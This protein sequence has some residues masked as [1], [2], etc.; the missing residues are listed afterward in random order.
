RQAYF[1]WEHHVS[2]ELNYYLPMPNN[3]QTKA[4]LPFLK[5][6]YESFI[7]AVEQW[8]GKKI[9]DED[10]DR[11]IEIMNRNRQLMRRVYETRKAEMP[12]IS[13]LEAMYMVVSSQLTHKE[14]HSDVLDELLK[15]ELPGRTVGGEDDIRL[16]SVGSE[17]DDIEFT[18][19]VESVG[20][21]IVI[22]DHCTGTRYFWS[23]VVP[24]EDRLAAIAERYIQRTACPTKDWPVRSRFEQIK[25]F[26]RDFDV[27]GVILVQQ[28][29]CDPH[30]IDFAALQDMLEEI[31]I[32]TLALEFDV[33]VPLGPFRIRVEAFLET[34]GGEELF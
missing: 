32:K 28:K 3:V 31:G 17:N 20:G 11:G 23:E 13:G 10:L 12:P 25:N 14:E 9:T 22:D 7:K 33:T 19:M 2:R 4:A 15:N 1:S 16:M 26:I 30:E 29:F 34:L 27:K 8:V 5:K 24:Q 18:E 21:R 6:E